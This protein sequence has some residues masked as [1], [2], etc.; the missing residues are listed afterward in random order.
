MPDHGTSGCPY[1]C[2]NCSDTRQEYKHKKKK[3]N[4]NLKF[5][6]ENLEFTTKKQV[7]TLSY[8]QEGKPYLNHFVF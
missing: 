3:T 8:A 7:K 5:D 6:E 1:T 2:K 4:R